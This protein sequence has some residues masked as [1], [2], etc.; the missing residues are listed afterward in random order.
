MAMVNEL[1]LEVDLLPEPELLFGGDHP[2]IDP[3]LGLLS[4]GPSGV[5]PPE[6]E[7][8]SIRLGA[9]GTFGVISQMRTFL[10]RLEYA[11]PAPRK[12]KPQPWRVDFP[13]LGK[14]G[15]LRFEMKLDPAAI[16]YVS[17]AEQSAVL[18]ESKRKKR[19]EKAV[20]LYQQKFEDFSSSTHPSPSLVLLP[21]SRELVERCK[22]PRHKGD[23][24][25]YERRT[26]DKRAKLAGTPVFD[27]HHVLKV[28]AFR[29][30]LP[31]QMLLPGTMSFKH[32]NQDAATVAWNFV[33]ASYYKGT[34]WPWKLTNIDDQT[35][36]VGM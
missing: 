20:D 25:L 14:E 5:R 13:G 17:D 36:Y 16:E 30:N 1:S 11:I 7:I 15:P 28:I 34:G 35:C 24:I 18:N 29:H 32:A 3:K 6:E 2:C 23:R 9:I 12:G 31:T 10:D 33:A 21:L 26:L 4:Y 27:F 22:S 19:I 8:R